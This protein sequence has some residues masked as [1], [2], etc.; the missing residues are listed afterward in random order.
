MFYDC[1]S[2]KYLNLISFNDKQN[3]VV[4]D[5]FSDN[6]KNLV[7]CID[8][9]ASSKI[10]EVIKSINQN[11]D[12]NNPWFTSFEDINVLNTQ[13]ILKLLKIKRLFI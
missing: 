6:L 13:K 4:D 1:T 9:E 3:L 10:L 11:N 7:Y 5:I 12:C 8:E 2:L